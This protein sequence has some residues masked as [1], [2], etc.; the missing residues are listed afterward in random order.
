[1]QNDQYQY[2]QSNPNPDYNFILNPQTP[3]KSFLKIGNLSAKGRLIVVGLIIILI[4][5]IF[6]IIKSLLTTPVFNQNDF[7]SLV[8]QQQQ[9]IHIVTVDV[10]TSQEQA[11]LTGGSINFV[12]SA[13]LVIS[14]D[15]AKTIKYLKL[16]GVT[17]NPQALNQSYS[18]TF[19]TELKNSLNTNTFTQ[20]M[21]QIMQSE[22]NIYKSDLL[23][24]YQTTNG[25]H[26]KVLLRQEYANCELLI[27]ELSSPNG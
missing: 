25:P 4:L 15:Q 8:K 1:M 16:N 7:L 11:N 12:T 10:Q 17:I 26:G 5:V 27:R 14:T 9:L 3:S 21:N 22:L 23:Q 20:T 2:S 24:T 13:N 6:A 19:D 18:P